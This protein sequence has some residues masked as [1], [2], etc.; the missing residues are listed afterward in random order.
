MPK[1]DPQKQQEGIDFI[2]RVYDERYAQ[3]TSLPQ[4]A[5]CLG[6]AYHETAGTMLPI[7]E[8]GNSAYFTRMY[9]PRG[10]RPHVA[11]TLGNVQPG[12]GAKFCGRGYVQLTGRANYRKATQKL[13]A[14]GYIG[15]DVDFEAN[16]DLVMNPTY[17]AIIMFEGMEEGWFTGKKLDAMIDDEVDGDEHG[18]FVRAR[19]IINGTDRDALIAGY[20][21]AFTNGLLAA[22]VA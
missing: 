21:D 9:D 2:C 1:I 14:R 16:P 5:Y 3:R 11:K 12:D 13:R 15:E 4:L 18:D 20:A 17:A 8:Y 6:T 22:R 7:K 19:R 10:S